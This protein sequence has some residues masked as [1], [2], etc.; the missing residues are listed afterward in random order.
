MAQ[1]T[2]T[3]TLFIGVHARGGI[4]GVLSFVDGSDFARVFL[5]EGDRCRLRS[6]VRPVDA[7]LV[8]AGLDE[9]RGPG[10]DQINEL[11]SPDNTSGC[12]GSGPV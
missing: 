4:S 6:F 5:T 3:S 10:P 8:T 9:V 2:C 11:G 7:V 12:P 1:M